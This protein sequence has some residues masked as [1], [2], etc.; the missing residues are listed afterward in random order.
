[1]LVIVGGMEVVRKMMNIKKSIH[2]I[3]LVMVTVIAIVVICTNFFVVYIRSLPVFTHKSTTVFSLSRLQGK[4][5][6]SPTSPHNYHPHIMWKTIAKK[7]LPKKKLD[8][9]HAVLY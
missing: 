1:M 9:F 7:N 3:S 4:N 2:H 6:D 8:I 5:T